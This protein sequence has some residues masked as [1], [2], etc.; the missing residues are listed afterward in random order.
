MMQNRMLAIVRNRYEY[1]VVFKDAHSQRFTLNIEA[2][3]A[4]SERDNSK[5]EWREPGKERGREKVKG[6]GKGT[7]RETEVRP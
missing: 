4:T 3:L 7:K 1:F 2:N 5:G 6:K